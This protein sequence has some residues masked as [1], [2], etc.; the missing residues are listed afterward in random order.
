M[1]KENEDSQGWEIGVAE[2]TQRGD[3]KFSLKAN[4]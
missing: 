4:R 1:A 2:K 3:G